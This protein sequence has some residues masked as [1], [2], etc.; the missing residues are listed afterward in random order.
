MPINPFVGQGIAQGFNEG[1][2]ALYTIMEK[3]KDR[4]REDE[5]FALKKKQL[6]LQIKELELGDADPDMIRLKKEKLKAD[7]ALQKAKGEEA[8]LALEDAR[9]TTT[10]RLKEFK[11]QV[12]AI[13]TYGQGQQDALGLPGTAPAVE[14]AGV[15]MG[16]PAGWTA[17]MTL[18]EEPTIKYETPKEKEPTWV[19]EQKVAS[20]KAGL[21]RGTG[22]ITKEWG[23]LEEE[24]VKSYAD[25]MKIIQF[26]KLDPA[27]FE[28]ELA[29]YKDIVQT[30]KAPDGR[31]V[32]KM[33]DGRVIYLDT[34][35]ETT[36]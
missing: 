36:E 17:E 26:N 20:V 15:G 12:N 6:D 7:V 10:E 29:F 8:D 33:K 11:D 30:G 21:R 28:D 3:K 27:D 4:K 1:A 23:A 32:A 19:Q 14:G 22:I 25:A 31:T 5:L 35:E 13:R 18:G 9:K 34:R 24:P 16:L 2:T